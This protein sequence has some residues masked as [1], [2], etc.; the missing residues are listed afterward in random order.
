MNGMTY[1]TQL[2]LIFSEY[3]PPYFPLPLR[4]Y[5]HQRYT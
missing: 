5:P 2:Y 1:I 3:Y 4:L